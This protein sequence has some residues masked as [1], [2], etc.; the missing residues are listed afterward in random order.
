MAPKITVLMSV[1]NGERF[2]R[3]AI[4]S[5]LSQTF[6]D[7]EFVIYDDCS[8][9][10]SRA[11]IQS[12]SDPRIVFRANDCNRGLTRNL[13]DGVV[14]SSAVYIARMDADDIAEKDRLAQQVA[15]MDSHL[16]VGFLGSN[17]RM[18]DGNGRSF[19]TDEPV[20]DQTIKCKLVLA[21]SLIHPTLM[22]RVSDLRKYNLNYCEDYRCS[23]DHD[24]YLRALPYVKMANLKAA[25]VRMRNHEHRI[26]CAKKG[27]QVE[28]S[29]RARRMFFAKL[30]LEGA[31]TEEEL[32]AYQLIAA[33]DFPE[34]ETV[35]LA[36]ESFVE[37]VQ[38][39]LGKYVPASTLRMV[40][41][42]HASCLAMRYLRTR[43]FYKASVAF[44]G[45]S[46]AARCDRGVMAKFKLWLKLTLIK[47]QLLPLV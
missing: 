47:M 29:N 3:E 26:T 36:Y 11:I 17:V 9:D 42:Q 32:A 46:L 28:C 19:C 37:K 33:Y 8:T 10:S 12:Y 15:Y 14:R 44:L 2:L 21:F 25:L 40:A 35:V 31:F 34:N 13:I 27:T 1:Y 41:A 22:M 24:L 30:G 7:F 38:K 20:D 39:G 5:V 45:T 4:D 6:K 18:F 23:Q 16:D 43:R